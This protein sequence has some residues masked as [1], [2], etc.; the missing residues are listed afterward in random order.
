M[1]AAYPAFSRQRAALSRRSIIW[2]PYQNVSAVQ[3]TIRFSPLSPVERDTVAKILFH[4]VDAYPESPATRYKRDGRWTDLTYRQIEERVARLAARLEKLGIEPGERVGLLS[5]NRPEWAIVDFACACS[6]IVDVPVYPTLPANQI[7]YMLRD[8]GA[9][10]V[11]AATREQV[12]SVLSVR[13]EIPSLRWIVALEQEHAGGEVLSF[14]DLTEGAGGPETEVMVRTL[15]EKGSARKP[16]DV[17]TIIY[18][19]GTTGAPKGVVLTQ[20]NLAYM[21]AATDQH[22]SLHVRNGETAL[23]LLPLSHIF[24]RGANYYY[25]DAGVTVAYAE[26][27]QKVAENLRE[28]RPHAVISVPR[29][30]EKIYNAVTAARGAR[31]QIVRWAM[32]TG[33]AVV[34]ERMR[35][36]EPGGLLGAQYRLADT[37]VFSKLRAQTGGRI[38]LFVSGGAPLSREVTQ[39]F[40]AAGMP[41][42]EGYGLT[43]TSPV[44]TANRPGAVRF[45]S[46]GVPYPGVELRLG[47]NSEI[48][49]R[50]PGLMQGYWNRPEL[51]KDAID[52]EGWFHTGDVGE[53]DE[54][55][56]LFITDRIKDLIVTAGGKNIAPQPIELH[57]TA[58]PYVAQAVMIGD[59]RPYPVMLVAP[60]WDSLKDWA[61]ANGI[62]ISNRERAVQDARVQ[63][64]FEQEVGR[65]L[66]GFARFEAPKKLR[67]LAAE[68][69]LEA[70][71]LTPT[72]KVRRQVVEKLYRTLIEELYAGA[73]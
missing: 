68:F 23:S 34:E 48:L 37:L 24:E 25:W 46:V 57:V 38:K 12:E 45:G 16:E 61:G 55:G 10:L 8:S 28:V 26:S 17:F 63:S 40:Y 7:A 72:L 35:G 4:A 14:R 41:V 71:T 20:Y 60:D 69:N 51:T 66:E 19:S 11:F 31:G 54:S 33:A 65:R 59:R 27:I 53:F 5:E 9:R 6:G 44:L 18:T 67:L 21:A 50:T 58:S 70:G 47:P 30:F 22:G 1:A 39:F 49:A 29:L 15:R 64:F 32:R 62:D 3:N 2:H 13:N 52:P 43:E 42:Y 56:A 36:R 73:G